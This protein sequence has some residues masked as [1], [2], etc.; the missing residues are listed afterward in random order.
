MRKVM[1]LAAML[2]MV[3]AAAAPVFAQDGDVVTGGDSTQY[4]AVCQNIIGSIG[5]ITAVQE[6]EANA[7]NAS[8][9][10]DSAAI[11][12]VAQE[13]GVSVAQVNECLNNFATVTPAGKK[14]VWIKGKKFVV[15]HGKTVTATATATPTATVA[16]Q[17]QYAPPTATATATAAAA[18]LPETGGAS[19]FAL[20]AGA[21]LVGGGLLARRI[22]R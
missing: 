1:L 21:L 2:A 14:V 9:L 17:V 8:D 20:G 15:V 6:G 4:N 5:D 11:A 10:D 19:L 16:A 3:L 7:G 13:Q 12:E 22:V 18:T